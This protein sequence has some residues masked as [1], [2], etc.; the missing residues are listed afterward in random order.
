MINADA[1]EPLSE[2]GA[3]LLDDLLAVLRKY[4]VLPD[5]HAEIAVTLWIAATHAMPAFECAPR[6]V[7]TSPDKRCGKSRLL[8]V[9]SGTCHEPLATS[10]ASVAA[11]FRSIGGEHPP[12]LL[13]DEADTKF[14]TKRVAE[15]NEDLR[16]LINAG[17][18]RGRPALRCV[19]PT[20]IPT[21]FPTF[22]MAALAAIGS[23]PDTITDRGVNVTMRR[24]TATEKVSQFRSRR[25]GPILAA[26]RDRLAEWASAH[27]DELAKTE[28]DMPVE[29]RAADTWEP[30]VAV[31]DV[32]GGDWPDAA[33]AACTAL[34]NQASDADEQQSLAVRLLADIQQVFDDRG[35]PFLASGDLVSELRRIEDAPW[36]DFDMNP[37]KLAYRLRDFGIRPG[38]NT[39]GSVRGYTLEALTDVFV[40]YLRQNPSEPSETTSEQQRRSDALDPT[41]TLDRQ[42]EN[43]RQA[44]SP[45]QD[46]F[47][48][49]LTTSDVPR[50]RNGEVGT[51]SLQPTG[52]P[53]ARTPGMT[54]RVRAALANAQTAPRVTGLGRCECGFHVETQ[55]H[56]DGCPH[57]ERT[58]THA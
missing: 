9:I 35:V 40:R 34:V 25:D 42:T 33:R 43:V 16:A 29:D 48:T 45:V 52:A 12:T 53:T 55:G 10:D 47:L 38:R 6:L 21:P 13:I 26:V 24:R 51:A 31:A 58:T 30:L 28:P 8:D 18:Q 37:S 32:A 41:D 57:T 44:E 49:G 1:V 3:A 46:T 14:G 19:G 17:H 2:D 39:I 7:A 22:A 20:Q 54:D 56:R 4:V 5:R 36:N 50:A 15:Q 11:V 27:L 23:L